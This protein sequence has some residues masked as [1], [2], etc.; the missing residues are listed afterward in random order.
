MNRLALCLS[1]VSVGLAGTAA[2][3]TSTPTTATPEDTTVTAPGAK[4]AKE[5]RVCRERGRA[6]SHLAN[7]VCKTP[8]EWAALQSDVDDQDEYGIPGARVAT[9]RA[10]DHGMPR[11][12]NQP[13]PN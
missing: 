7:R 3:Q 9:G 6:G 12:P 11:H 1:L 2:A 13:R 5:K 4:P 8:A 10:I